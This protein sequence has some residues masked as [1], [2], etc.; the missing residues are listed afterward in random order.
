[1][2]GANYRDLVVWQRSIMENEYVRKLKNAVNGNIAVYID[3]ANLEQSVKD[4]FVRP[5]DISSELKNSSAEK[6][7][8]SV[9]YK[10]LNDFF[11]SL[12]G[13]K[14]VR[15]YTAAFEGEGHYK[16]RYFLNK[17]LQFKLITKPL[18][19]YEDHTLEIPHRKANFDVEIA[20][21]ATASLDSFDTMILFS[22]DCDFEY[23]VKFFRGKGK[24]VIGFSRSGHVAKELPPVLSYYFDIANF[25][26]V[27]M[28]IAQKAKNPE[29]FGT[30]LRS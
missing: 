17:G 6:L 28:K 30:G 14:G 21:D 23:L 8:W 26:Q 2:K 20:V 29:P 4:M 10:K 19:E 7:K 11:V 9:D 1:M 16:F 5:D 27:F 24:I 18:K 12:G 22:G 13:F 25:R 3:A 15:F